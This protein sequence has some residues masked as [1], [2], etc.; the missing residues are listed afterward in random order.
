MRV[1][2]KKRNL[3][4][5]IWKKIIIVILGACAAAGLMACYPEMKHSEIFAVPVQ[6]ETKEAIQTRLEELLENNVGFV[7]RK[8]NKDYNIVYRNKP[9]K[10]MTVSELF[11][12]SSKEEKKED[13]PLFLQWDERWGY[14][15]YGDSCIGI[16]GC[17]PT[18]LS[19]VIFSLT[20]DETAT[21]DALAD[22]AMRH[23]YY[24]QGKGTLWS[25]LTDAGSKYSVQ[26]TETPLDENTMKAQL[27]EGHP[28]IA[29]MRP[30]DFTTE[31]H[32]IV[33]YGYDEEGFLVH[34]PNSRLRS[35]EEW[36]FQ[37][38]YPQIK[39]LWAYSME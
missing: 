35:E 19:M 29:S 11:G 18:C 3:F 7:E 17:A 25:F 33:I 23:N 14:A 10:P 22:Y 8:Q 26:G 1:V 30:G 36:T 9:N 12:L 37:T 16:S 39:N 38:L 31:G 5:R 4:Q 21:P 34:D 24:V 32:F 20:R 15:S 28:I 2:C 6:Q 27:D 13:S